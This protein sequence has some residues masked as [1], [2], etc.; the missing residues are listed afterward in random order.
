MLF[1]LA[2]CSSDISNDEE[3][4]EEIL[5]ALQDVESVETSVALLMNARTGAAGDSDGHTGSMTADITI[6]S[7]FHPYAYHAELFSRV[8]VDGAATGENLE[9]YV[10]PVD[11]DYVQY[12]YDES[13]DSWLSTTLGRE[14]VLSL[15]TKTGF[16]TDWKMLLANI[17][18][19]AEVEDKKE[20][21]VAY[22]LTGMVDTSVLQE[23]FGN[24]VFNTFMDS[25]ERLLADEVPYVLLVDSETLLPQQ[26]SISFKDYFLVSDMTFDVAEIIVSYA[27]YNKIHEIE[28]PKKISIAARDPDADFYNSFFAWN[29]FLPYINGS[30]DDPTG[31]GGNGLIFTSSWETFQVRIDDRMTELPLSYE[32]LSKLGYAIDSSAS[33]TILEPNTYQENIPVMK[34]SDKLLCSFYNPET[35]PQPISSCLIAGIDIS[36]S[37]LPHNGIRIYMPGEV[38]LGITR[39]ALESAYGEPD[40]VVAG[41][42]ADTLT[43]N[44]E[45]EGQSFMAEVS[46]LTNLV[47]RLQLRNI[48]SA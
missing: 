8:L 37:N 43:W 28:V 22:E 15:G 21:I 46:P 31:N 7:T 9:Y 24:K 30:T 11:Q 17:E 5:E 6:S 1:A 41:F 27:E 42:A 16:F 12:A 19:F 2:G 20:E 4:A 3:A 23:L 48:P 35:T 10:I 14:E 13:T 38:R 32:N 40:N 47:I 36:A 18:D 34:G 33:N 39:E 29:L 25:T 26:L 45:R 44:G